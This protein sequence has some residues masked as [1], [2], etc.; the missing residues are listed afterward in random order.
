MNRENYNNF[1]ICKLGLPPTIA[2]SCRSTLTTEF[3]R[4]AEWRGREEEATWPSWEPLEVRSHLCGVGPG[5]G[6]LPLDNWIGNDQYS[7]MCEWKFSYQSDCFL[8]YWT[9]FD[10]LECWI[11]EATR[12]PIW[13][14]GIYFFGRE[15]KIPTA[16]WRGDDKFSAQKYQISELAATLNFV[17]LARRVRGRLGLGSSMGNKRVKDGRRGRV[18]RGWGKLGV[19][20][21]LPDARRRR[22]RTTARSLY[23]ISIWMQICCRWNNWVN[24]QQ[25]YP[26]K[27]KTPKYI[28][29]CSTY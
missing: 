9:F 11:N 26:T 12:R 18:G 10:D 28:C 21:G 24:D 5:G 23:D 27:N 6:K 8:K 15:G 25:W 3:G 29:R 22:L 14:A 2:D 16:R 13:T 1:Q 4:A 19:G 17:F 20:A 7:I